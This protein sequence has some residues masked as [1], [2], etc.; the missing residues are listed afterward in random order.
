MNN[1]II[2]KILS[3]LIMVTELQE[4][5]RLKA[6][7]VREQSFELATTLREKEI[8]LLNQLP[9]LEQIKLWREQITS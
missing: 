6:C 7:A 1:E 2:N 3:Y 8:E 5:K 9:T 4:V